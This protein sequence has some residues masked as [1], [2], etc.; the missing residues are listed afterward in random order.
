MMPET[1]P[2]MLGAPPPEQLDTPL[3]ELPLGQQK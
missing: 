2:A 1:M 3:H